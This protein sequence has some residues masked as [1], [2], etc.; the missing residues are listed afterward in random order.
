MPSP[1]LPP[2]PPLPLILAWTSC[3]VQWTGWSVCTSRGGVRW[4]LLLLIWQQGLR[5]PLE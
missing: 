1:P 5:W 4:R 3:W 2:L